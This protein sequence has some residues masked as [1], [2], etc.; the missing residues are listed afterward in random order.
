MCD[1]V[2]GEENSVGASKSPCFTPVSTLKGSC[3][4]TTNINTNLHLIMEGS[5][6]FNKVIRT[7]QLSQNL[8]KCLS[9][10]TVKRFYQINEDLVQALLYN[11]YVLTCL[12]YSCETWVVYQRHLKHLERFRQR[13]LWSVLGIHWITHTPGTEVLEKANMIKIEAHIHRHRLRWVGHVVRLALMITSLVFGVPWKSCQLYPYF[14]GTRTATLVEL[15]SR[16]RHW[17]VIAVYLPI[18]FRLTTKE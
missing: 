17:I 11:A 12:L 9:V 14:D 16:F 18:S 2:D 4:Y 15:F 1:Q 5:D 6:Q 8:P 10:N 7:S 13:C 3:K